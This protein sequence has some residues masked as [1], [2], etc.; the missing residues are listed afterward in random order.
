MKIHLLCFDRVSTA[1]VP[2]GVNIYT[3]IVLYYSIAS[4]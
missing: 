1:I 3:F 2:I 4:D